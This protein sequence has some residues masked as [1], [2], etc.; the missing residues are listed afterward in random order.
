MTRRSRTAAHY[1][2]PRTKAGK[3][4]AT[5][6]GQPPKTKRA[7]MNKTEERFADH[8]DTWMTAGY[9]SAWWFE[10]MSWKLA[11]AT[12]Y[13]PDFLTQHADGAL[14]VYEVKAAKGRDYMTTPDAWVKLKIAA[15]QMPYPLTVAWQTKDAHWHTEQLN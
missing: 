13:M 11:D 12:R 10:P 15:E 3:H 14:H 5:G 7:G 4:A 8:L 6:V 1:H 9:I 2:T